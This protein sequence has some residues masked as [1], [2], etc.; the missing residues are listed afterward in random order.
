[1]PANMAS[2]STRATRSRFS[3]PQITTNGTNDAAKGTTANVRPDG[4]RTLKDWLEPPLNA[5]ASYQD[6][7]LLKHGV[8]ENMAPLGTMPKVGLFRK[9]VAPA[10][11]TAPENKTPS[12]KII[13]KRPVPPTPAVAP[14][15][16]ASTPAPEED[17]TEEEEEEEVLEEHKD[18]R[19]FDLDESGRPAL[20]RRSLQ[21]REDLDDDWAPGKSSYKGYSRRSMSRA[22]AGR[23]GSMSSS[24]FQQG[25]PH[26]RLSD[27]K[28]LADQVIEKAV[29]EALSSFRY[30]TAFALR[31]LYDDKCDDEAFLNLLVKVFQQTA[32]P[33]ELEEFGRLMAP[34]KRDGKNEN[35]GCYYFVP[36]TTNNRFTPHEPKIAPYGHLVKIDLSPLRQITSVDDQS[37]PEI[38][39]EPVAEATAQPEPDAEVEPA[40]EQEPVP[41]PEPAAEPEPEP[42]LE[43][44]LEP[45]LQPQPE[46]VGKRELPQ[47]DEPQQEQVAEQE[48]HVRK[49]RRSNRHSASATKM[50][51]NGVNGKGKHIS[52]SKRRTRANSQSST[53]SLSSARSLTPP[54]EPQQDAE[55][56]GAFEVPPSRTSPA[57]G[58]ASNEVISATRQSTRKGRRR[59]VAPRKATKGNAS[60]EPSASKASTPT[61]THLAASSKQP[62]PA[63]QQDG[64]DQ[65]AAEQPYDMPAVVDSPLFPN[66]NPKK[67]NKSVSNGVSFPSKVGKIDETDKKLLLRQTARAVT[68]SLE[69]TVEQSFARNT[70][71]V[72]D[73]TPAPPSR[74]RTSLPTARD[75]P[76]ATAATSRTRSAARKRSHNDDAEEQPSPTTINFAA[77]EV[78]PSTAATSRAGTPALRPAK[79]QK[80]GLRVKNSPVKKK[81]STSAGIPR[82]SGERNSPGAVL[83]REDDNDD[84]CGSCSGNGELICCDG[85][86]RSFHFSCVD[87]PLPPQESMPEDSQWFCNVCQSS[88]DPSSFQAHDGAFA[89]LDEKLDARNSSAFRLPGPV[90]DLFENV[91][92]GPDGEYEENV[93]VP[94]APKKKKSDEDP[95]TDI[96][97]LRDAEG[98][99]IICHNCQKSSETT[100]AIIPCS[101][102]GLF[103]HLD[104]LDPPLANP[105]VLRTWK[106]P[107]HI[108]DVV[109]KVPGTLGPAHKFRKIKN[110]PVIK[111]A[112]SRGFI[113]N[114]YIEIDLDDNED[115]SGWKDVQTFGRTVRLPEKGIKLDFLSSVRENRKG[116]PIP[117]LMD[118]LHP[119]A[120]PK[121]HAI[122]KATLN[123]QQA[124]YNLAQLSGQGTAPLD[125]LVDTLVAEADP[126]VIDLMARSRPENLTGNSVLDQMD[127]QGLRAMYAQLSQMRDRIEQRLHH[128]TPEQSSPQPATGLSGTAHEQPARVPSLT[129]SQTTE[130]E[131]ENPLTNQ[132]TPYGAGLDSA[133]GSKEKN[134]PSPAATDVVMPSN[135]ADDGANGDGDDD[136][137]G[138]S[139]ADENTTAEDNI[140]V[141]PTDGKMLNCDDSVVVKEPQSNKTAVEIEEDGMDLD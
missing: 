72:E 89:L 66:P 79:R 104:C 58:T 130:A 101:V 138:S 53:S 61:A 131:S 6:A 14:P 49:K 105:P 13:L 123:R 122:D 90:R 86:T 121:Q 9:A 25:P 73:T 44:S 71:A 137:L 136:Q 27:L 111:P 2:S 21:S 33:E 29:D 81:G 100:R 60:S 18:H 75:T 51:A 82:G 10:P 62:T 103:W 52:P 120:A 92:T 17:E 139:P 96:F 69:A 12:R 55:E 74:S 84:Y 11:I 50:S 43:A 26:Y 48:V 30:P 59:S 110:S 24:S 116:K 117:P 32:S 108:E 112:F 34:R 109:S 28:E 39:T 37:E 15:V 42:K 132:Q 20:T 128:R 54:E 19:G 98:N 93:T 57:A 106:C 134:L 40:P 3:S 1:M 76:T 129:H 118:G 140:P 23:Y 41:E 35:K 16:V 68:R 5:K 107:C 22:S 64:S 56:A 91:R 127:E 99:L 114:G 45:Q 46:R 67:G 77:S 102:C 95:F 47:D 63:P 126:A 124:A 133:D 115:Q 87:P 80:T 38:S 135:K 78:A 94:K 141:T 113:N 65:I 8:V 119:P 70:P 4:Q 85:C 36:P 83:S 88:R 31:T 97:R 125:N 7:G